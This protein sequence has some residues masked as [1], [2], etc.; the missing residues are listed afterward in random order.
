MKHKL[1][2]LNFGFLFCM[3]LCLFSVSLTDAQSPSAST[4]KVKLMTAEDHF[5]LAIQRYKQSFSDLL[6]S[7]GQSAKRVSDQWEEV[8]SRGHSPLS[9]SLAIDSTSAVT[10]ILRQ[11]FPSQT[12]VLFYSY[13]SERRFHS[14]FITQNGLQAYQ[15]TPLSLEKLESAIANLRA[16]LGVNSTLLTRTIIRPR[17]LVL[18]KVEVQRPPL[19]PAIAEL[20]EILLPRNVANEIAWTKHLIVVPVL[21]IGAVPFGVLRPA[22]NYLVDTTSVSFAP[23]LF[24]LEKA[25]S[26]QAWQSSFQSPLVVGNP[27]LPP[28]PDWE[29][30]PLP[31]AEEE[32]TAIAKMLG[33][34]PL[35]GSQATKA[36]VLAQAGDADFLLLG[37][38][39]A[40]S[41]KEPL[42][43]SFL[44]LSAPA[45]TQGWWTALEVQRVRL[46]A[47]IA[48]LSACQTGLGRSHDAGT[49]G[50]ARAFQIAGVP[51]VVMS[52]WNVHDRA[53]ASLMKSFVRHLANQMP[54]EALRQAM[55]DTRRHYPKPSEWA[56]FVLFGLPK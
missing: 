32:A 46:K 7:R 41:N 49:I 48:V 12:A 56:S 17:D 39:G 55:L 25:Q 4:P 15:H 8:F 10:K 5:V 21:G 6:K 54:A 26:Y 3:A 51:R 30:P 40:S 35:I 53:T 22:S 28:D 24:D 36:A 52:L 19:L 11:H 23:S 50:L 2:L 18:R 45:F 16:A 9:N 13:D 42:T 20:T 34:T 43:S 37:T 14:W 31:G 38:H 44:A 27:Y 33:A 1:A 29:T 47:R